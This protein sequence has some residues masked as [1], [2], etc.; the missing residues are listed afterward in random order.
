M[1]LADA[2]FMRASLASVGIVLDESKQLIAVAPA[3][4]HAHVD[5][6][7]IRLILV[8]AG[9]PARDI[10]WLTASCPSLD[11]ALGYVPPRSIR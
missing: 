9:A 10:D 8:E 11:H 2:K 7:M 6:D 1:S 3:V 5:R 4:M